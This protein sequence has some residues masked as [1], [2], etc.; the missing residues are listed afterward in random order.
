MGMFDKAKEVADKVKDVTEEQ[1]DKL[2]G[3]IDKGADKLKEKT[4]SE[5]VDEV[6]EPLQNPAEATSREGEPPPTRPAP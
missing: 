1:V 6:V 4:D 5:K 2:G 3:L